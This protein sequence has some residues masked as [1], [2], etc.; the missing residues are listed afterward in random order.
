MKYSSLLLG[1]LLFVFGCDSGP[2]IV[3]VSG[4][5]LVDGKPLPTGFVQVA[6]SGYR[7]ASGKVAPDGTFSLTTTIENDGC[8][9]GTH[10][11]A[12]IALESLGPTSQKW[13]A[14]KSYN[15][16]E[17]SGLTVTIDK[18]TNNLKIELTWKGGRPFVEKFSKE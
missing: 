15:S 5:V 2:K 8:V 7:A 11:A 18:P 4:I 12:V 13:H 10:P 14:P 17:T 1:I 6:P 9:M 16:T 3:K